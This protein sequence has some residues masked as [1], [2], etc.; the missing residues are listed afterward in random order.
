MSLSDDKAVD[1][2]SSDSRDEPHNATSPEGGQHRVLHV[3]YLLTAVFVLFLN[4]FLAQYDKFIL[5]YF[6]ADVIASLNLTAV[7]YAVLSGYATSIVYALLAIPVAFIADY[8][9]AR[10]W[11]L[12]VAALWYSLCTLLQ[13]LSHNFWQIL[14]ARI[15]MGIGQAPVE[16]LSISLISDL[17][18][19]GWLF[20]CESA[21]YVAVYV[22]EAVSGQIAT[23]FNA[24]G[25]PWNDA[26]KA[27]G[28][29]GMVLAVIIRL[30]LREPL[31]RKSLV[32]TAVEIEGSEHGTPHRLNRAKIQFLASLSQV[33]RMRSFWL[34]TLSSGS[35]Q[36]SGNVF[37]WYVSIAIS[38][39]G[40]A[41]QSL[42]NEQMPA[43]LTS[44][45]TKESDLLSKYGIIVGAVGSV[46]VLLGG[47]LS[48]IA[49]TREG[50]AK[51]ALL[52]TVIGG[53]ISAPFVVVMVFSLLAANGHQDQGT[54]IL[55][56]SM[57]AA[58]ITAELWLGAF[59]SVLALILP[60]QTKTFCLAI[61]TS[62]IILIY[63]SAPEMIGLSVRHYTVGSPAYI[64][65]TRKILAILIP[66]G[67][68]LGAVGFLYAIREVGRDLRGDYPE[69]VTIKRKL[70]FGMGASLLASLTIALFVVSLTIKGEQ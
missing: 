67:Y 31:R 22:G 33:I 52:L 57:S 41:I 35:R 21:L 34:L 19:P 62:T 68:V 38:S 30:I 64:V 50:R 46:A 16:A 29:V 54:T 6:Q 25:T 65:E 10:V 61:Y 48:S 13:G 18:D 3:L 53:I 24:T 20:L 23:A 43:Y 11:T 14:L 1:I 51:I 44:I 58:Y 2:V 28:I 56:G 70:C 60:P 49:K 5:S 17:V 42:T 55:Y 8:T 69:R 45:Y 36:F 47:I 40:S 59:A 37:G 9:S 15:G 32:P 63:S 39:S 66:V 4:F 27:I 7:D 12:A 26:L